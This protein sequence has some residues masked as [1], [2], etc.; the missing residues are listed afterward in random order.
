MRYSFTL[1]PDEDEEDPLPSKTRRERV[2]GVCKRSAAYV[3]V[4]VAEEDGYNEHTMEDFSSLSALSK[5]KTEG[6]FCWPK[7][8]NKADKKQ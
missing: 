6:S 8:E 7:N 4:Y 2:C 1:P 5:K 3:L